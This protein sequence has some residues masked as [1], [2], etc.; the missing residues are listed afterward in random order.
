[1]IRFNKGDEIQGFI[2][3]HPKINEI[4]KGFSVYKYLLQE[5]LNTKVNPELGFKLFPYNCPKLLTFEIVNSNNPEN[6][7][8][9]DFA[10]RLSPILDDYGF[11]S[12]FSIVTNAIFKAIQI[13]RGRLDNT[14][15]TKINDAIDVVIKFLHEDKM[16]GINKG[17][18]THRLDRI[19]THIYRTDEIACNLSL[20]KEITND[21][22]IDLLDNSLPS[23]STVLDNLAWSIVNTI[24]VRNKIIKQD[25]ENSHLIG[26]IR[27]IRKDFINQYGKPNDS[28]I[29]SLA[30]ILFRELPSIA[31]EPVSTDRVKNLK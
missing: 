11:K 8:I 1:M 17:I 25:S 12:F 13:E 22:I 14:Q 28:I 24:E 4:P 2:N 30:N 15:L 23:L 31:D 6:K 16:F 10:L 27:I 21:E 18:Q 20:D 9:L 19:S 3:S 7:K 29:A 26:F 5:E